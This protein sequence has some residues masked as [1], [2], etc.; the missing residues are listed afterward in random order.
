[1]VEAPAVTPNH[2]RPFNPGGTKILFLSRILAPPTGSA[3]FFRT[4]VP[5]LAVDVVLIGI[6]AA[7]TVLVA[8]SRLNR[9]PLLLDITEEI[10]V[11]GVILFFKFL[12]LSVLLFMS[13]RRSREWLFRALAIVF[14]ILLIDDTLQFHE[15]GG[16]TLFIML[17]LKD[18]FG[19]E[20][21]DLGELLA[22]C[23]IGSVCV[24]FLAVGFVKASRRARR[25]ALN[26]FAAIVALGMSGIVFDMIH[27]ASLLIDP[28]IPALTF[29]AGL[30]ED[31]GEIVVV[32]A[33]L[34]YAA[35]TLSEAKYYRRSV[36]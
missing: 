13:W 16:E 18:A 34:A 21:Q 8:T 19:L 20:R 31:G 29:A 35:S 24:L 6:H 3:V 22:W 23:I 7:S 27:S 25:L 4:L 36:E 9:T 2:D 15:R 30:A 10:S 5:L 1:M 11:A 26:Y 28:A 32:S 17:Q 12:M 33:L 14:A